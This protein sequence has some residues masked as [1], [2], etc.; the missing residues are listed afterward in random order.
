MGTCG[1]T[2]GT[3]RINKKLCFSNQRDTKNVI[4]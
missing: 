3:S 2:E 4:N 1:L